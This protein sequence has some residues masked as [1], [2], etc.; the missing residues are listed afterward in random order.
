MNSKP[1]FEISSKE[2][3]D[4]LQT[5]KEITL[6]DVRSPQAFQ[7]WSLLDSEN[8]PLRQLFEQREVMEDL[9]NKQIVTICTRGNDSRMAAKILQNQGINALS[10]QG[11][12]KEWNSVLDPVTLPIK[13]PGLRVIQFRRVAKG[14]LSYII[15]HEDEAVV[16]DPVYD[17]THYKTYADK[18]GLTITH[19]LDTHCHADHV[20]GARDLSNEMDAELHLSSYDPFHY[21]FTPFKKDESIRVGKYLIRTMHTPGHTKGSTTIRLKHEGIFTGDTVFADGVGRPDLADKVEEFAGELFDTLTTRIATLPIDE[22]IAAGHH[23]KFAMN[24]FHSPI[25]TTIEEFNRDQV[26]QIEKEE[27]VSKAAKILNEMQKPPSYKTIIEINSGDLFLTPDQIHEL[28]I[29]P[30]RCALG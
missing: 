18:E 9:K 2:L 23:G 6:L 29:G 19:V 14:C 24:H 21:E 5:N 3:H 10:L 17:T 26:H 13:E 20:S 30:N 27:F 28:E 22:F 8:L 4:K 1:H 25:V 11:G 12:L 15:A 16:I 7:E